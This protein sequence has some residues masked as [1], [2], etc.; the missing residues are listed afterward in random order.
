MWILPKLEC[1]LLVKT[2]ADVYKES[3]IELCDGHL[4]VG[5]EL[6]NGVCACLRWYRRKKLV[7]SHSVKTYL[8]LKVWLA[9]KISLFQRV[10][11]K[12]FLSS[13]I[14]TGLNSLSFA[15]KQLIYFKQ[16]ATI[17]A[18][19]QSRHN[20]SAWTLRV[21]FCT[22]LESCIFISKV[23]ISLSKQIDQEWLRSIVEW[24]NWYNWWIIHRKGKKRGS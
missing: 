15:R 9:R 12:L 14:L 7:E 13:M 4:F 3:V 2:I 16:S 19:L 23:S 6:S 5:D 21:L 20:T 17:F 1:H 10:Y 18:G 22:Q 8:S 24:H 11:L